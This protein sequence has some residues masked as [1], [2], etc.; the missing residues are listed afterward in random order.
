MIHQTVI[1]RRVGADD[2]ALGIL[3]L[4]RTISESYPRRR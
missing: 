1:G 3:H 4:F 2:S